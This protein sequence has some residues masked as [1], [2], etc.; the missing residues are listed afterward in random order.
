MVLS[1]EDKIIIEVCRQEFGNH[2]DYM[3]KSVDYYYRV[4]VCRCTVVAYEWAD[5]KS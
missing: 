1:N 4:N 5:Q 2:Y 3:H